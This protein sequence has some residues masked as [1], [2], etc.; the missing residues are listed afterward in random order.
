MFK[1]VSLVENKTVDSLTETYK[2]VKALL[3]DNLQF[4]KLYN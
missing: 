3:K 4:R 1:L 2:W